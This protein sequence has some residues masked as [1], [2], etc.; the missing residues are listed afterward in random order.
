MVMTVGWMVP[1]SMPEPAW[2]SSSSL[3]LQPA[4]LDPALKADPDSAGLLSETAHGR[5]TLSPTVLCS[6]Y[7]G[8]EGTGSPFHKPPSTGCG[9][10]GDW[11]LDS[12]ALAPLTRLQPHLTCCLGLGAGAYGPSSI[13]PGKV[14]QYSPS[15][16]GGLPDSAGAGL[17][18]GSWVPI[19]LRTGLLRD[20]RHTGVPN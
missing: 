9:A 19:G 4:W 1:D 11:Y 5:P 6:A 14:C 2:T 16:D 8:K 17:F 15:P 7:L 12:P 20:L 3:L 10:A 13:F 18:L